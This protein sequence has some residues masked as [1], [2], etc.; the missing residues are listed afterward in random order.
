MLTEL[1]FT[2]LLFPLVESR[3]T[4]VP[5]LQ[6]ELDPLLL[7]ASVSKL[8]TLELLSRVNALVLVVLVELL[9]PLIEFLHDALDVGFEFGGLRFLRSRSSGGTC[10]KRGFGAQVATIFAWE[11]LSVRPRNRSS[12]SKLIDEVWIETLVFVGRCIEEEE[13]P[14]KPFGV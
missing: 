3:S 14:V 13:E 8:L 1:P 7:V 4:F 12:R 5:L 6:F 9:A 11:A 2:L 10:S